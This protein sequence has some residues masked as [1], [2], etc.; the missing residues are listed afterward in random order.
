[1][2]KG[3]SVDRLSYYLKTQGF[4]HHLVE[5]GGELRGAASSRTASRGG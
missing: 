4:A 5:V 2:A 1:V 3:Y